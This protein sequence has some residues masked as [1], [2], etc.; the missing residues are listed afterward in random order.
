[1]LGHF[2]V[3]M[4]IG[5]NQL[6]VDSTKSYDYPA[7]SP[8]QVDVTCGAG[9]DFVAYSYELEDLGGVVSVGERFYGITG[10]SNGQLTSESGTLVY[11]TNG[12]GFVDNVWRPG[13]AFHFLFLQNRAGE[14]FVAIEDLPVDMSDKDYNDALYR[15][16]V[17]AVPVP[18]PGTLVLLMGGMAGYAV[19]VRRRR[20]RRAGM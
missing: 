15:L 11:R 20:E 2:I 14:L 3:A 13:D 16:H 19:A 9:Q 6:P 12:W 7:M 10:L 1:M 18:E 4:W 17:T 8:C 5:I